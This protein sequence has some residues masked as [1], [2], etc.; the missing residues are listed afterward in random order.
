LFFKVQI[1]GFRTRKYS[2]TA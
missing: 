2:C 1:Q